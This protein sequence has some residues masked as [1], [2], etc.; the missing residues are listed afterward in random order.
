[1]T[2]RGLLIDCLTRLNQTRLAYMLT[3]SMASNY[4]GLPRT[5]HDLDFVVQL[6]SADVPAIMRAFEADYVV[7]ESMVRSATLRPPRQFNVIDPRSGLKIDFWLLTADPFERSMFARR[8]QRNVFGVP[9]WIATPEDVILHKLY[10][11][12]LT[13]SERQLADAAGVVAIREK[14]LD[15]D[16]LRACAKQLAVTETLEK[17]LSKEIRPKTT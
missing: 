4:W 3:G 11:N 6:E 12:R 7:Q 1:M 9:V 16:Y 17:L 5:T 10:W 14:T 13:P 8:L 15:V 2:E